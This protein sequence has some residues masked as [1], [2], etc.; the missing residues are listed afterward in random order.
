MSALWLS[1]IV[2]ITNVEETPTGIAVQVVDWNTGAREVAL[3]FKDLGQL[4]T[5]NAEGARNLAF[6]L[7]E[8]ADFIEPPFSDEPPPASQNVEENSEESLSIFG[9]YDEEVLQNE[10]DEDEDEEDDTDE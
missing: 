6:L 3:H 1:K 4:L 2:Y 10:E 5:L 7:M 8:C 9:P